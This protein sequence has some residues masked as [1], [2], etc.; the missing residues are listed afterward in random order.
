VSAT[1]HDALGV[2]AD[3]HGNLAALEAVL[4]DLERRSVRNIVNL[5]DCVSGP[6]WPRETLELL[7][8][9]GFPT[10]RGNHDRWVFEQD[11]AE[12]SR[13][14][15][16]A[17]THLDAAQRAWLGALPLT[18]SA[19]EIFAFHARPDDDNQY[20]LE[21]VVG[22]RL[23][24]ASAETIE[25]RLAGHTH[26]FMLCGHSHLPNIVRLAN[27]TTVLNPG[28]VGFPAYE[29]TDPSHISESG[30]PHARYAIIRDGAIELIAL[31]YDHAS[32]AA[33]AAEND[34]PDWA[35][36]LTTGRARSSTHT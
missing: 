36:F 18:H 8:A 31:E 5:G 4:A 17:H 10:V 7:I 29:D 35:Q 15:R 6:L 22:D 30:A 20:L 25:Q 24:P 11:P 34:R 16:F 28:S 21:D 14:D 32:A 19:G 27:G 9:R 1:Q 13:I 23:F 26:R 3:I 33:R 12:M 2:I